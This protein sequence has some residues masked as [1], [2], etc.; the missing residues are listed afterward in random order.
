[1]VESSLKGGYLMSALIGLIIVAW[2]CGVLGELSKTE[3][4][5][6]KR[7]MNFLAWKDRKISRIWVCPVKE[8]VVSGKQEFYFFSGCGPESCIIKKD[9]AVRHVSGL[10][11]IIHRYEYDGRLKERISFVRS[12]GEGEDLAIGNFA[13]RKAIERSADVHG[14]Y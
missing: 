9:L 4:S 10:F 3:T 7:L 6:G 1:M 5:V 11:T 8:A 12:I 2:L 14:L 13:V